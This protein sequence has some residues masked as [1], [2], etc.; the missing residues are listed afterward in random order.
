METVIEVWWQTD[1]VDD[2]YPLVRQG[3]LIK[4]E[5]GVTI[6]DVLC[7]QLGIPHDYLDNRINTIFLDGSAVD[8]VDTA[9]VRD[10]CTLALSASMPG[11]VGATMRKGGAFASLRNGIT[12]REPGADSPPALGFFKLRLYNMVCD[13]QGAR[14]LASG[15]WVD[16][17]ALAAFLEGS[18]AT[19]WSCCTACR[20]DG[21]AVEP[22]LLTKVLTASK[23]GLVR[24][25]VVT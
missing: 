13:E 16:V 21:S 4:A 20:V 24:I 8:D 15:V 10:R 17:D 19:L 2:W 3:V 14:L 9:V 22:T 23:P 11:L 12:H 25:H 7:R 18:A 6:R 1:S 5:V